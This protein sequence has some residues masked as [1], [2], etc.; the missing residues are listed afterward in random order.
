MLV[1][2]PSIDIMTYIYHWY[3]G[4]LFGV[5]NQLT[6]V[7]MGHQLEGIHTPCGGPDVA[8]DDPPTREKI[9]DGFPHKSIGD[10]AQNSL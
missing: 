6:A 9:G 2:K 4:E 10:V 3:H 5:C 7:T 8:D 1:S